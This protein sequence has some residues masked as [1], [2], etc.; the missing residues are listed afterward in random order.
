MLADNNAQ[1]S[2]TF[3]AT[4]DE[5][6]R[7]VIRDCIAGNLVQTEKDTSREQLYYQM[8]MSNPRARILTSPHR[9]LNLVVAVARFAWLVGANNRVEDIAYYEPKVAGFSDDGLTVPGSDYG[10]R[11]FQPRPGLDQIQGVIKRLRD[12]P[13][14]RQAAAVVWQP[15]DAVRASRDIPCTHGMFFHVR[16][17]KL[18]MGVTMRSN[19]AFRILPFNIFEFSML[20]EMVAMEI[21]VPLGDYNVWAASMHVYVNDREWTPTV[22][23]A[24]DNVSE[25]IVMP[26]MPDH[27][28]NLWPGSSPMQQ[29]KRLASFEAQLRH[30]WSEARMWEIMAA[31]NNSLE[32]YWLELLGVLFCWGAAKRGYEVPYTTVH[33][34]IR[35]LVQVACQKAYED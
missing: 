1:L 9:P 34:D 29:A 10:M 12:Q 17:D 13:L 14:S 3:P 27:T 16:D 25:S 23:I 7:R 6:V 26:H 31:A 22:G 21:G 30:A 11:L 32:S 33:T 18:H 5:M 8:G 35:D 28:V 15:E 19:N 24:M 2:D 4:A 20:H